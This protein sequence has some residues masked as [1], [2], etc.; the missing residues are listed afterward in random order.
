M[1]RPEC[2]RS[3]CSI[4][5]FDKDRNLVFKEPAAIWGCGSAPNL[6]AWDSELLVDI[7]DDRDLAET[8]L[9]EC[10]DM[11]DSDL[12][13]IYA[14]TDIKEQN[15]DLKVTT[16]PSI[17]GNHIYMKCQNGKVISDRQSITAI[18]RP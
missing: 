16:Q 4:P 3:T 9:L 7:D 5:G 10:A 13:G 6:D 14:N 15:S 2:I 11:I 8:A 18:R 1:C 12:Q 17:T